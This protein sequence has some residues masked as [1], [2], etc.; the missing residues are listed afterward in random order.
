MAVAP[1]FKLEEDESD[2]EGAEE[3][4]NIADLITH[5]HC[6][7]CNDNSKASASHASAHAGLFVSASMWC[8]SGSWLIRC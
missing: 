1:G 7:L 5:I 8:Q 6:G 4:V 2:G 3:P